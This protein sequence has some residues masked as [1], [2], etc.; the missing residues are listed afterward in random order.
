MHDVIIVG[1][2]VAGLVCGRQLLR[3]G[4]DVLLVEKSAGLGGRM[5]TRRIAYKSGD[6]PIAVDHGAQYITADTD[7]FHRLI[8][9][10]VVADVLVEWTRSIHHL[11]PTG[12]HPG[13]VD[14][15]HPRYSSPLGM[16]AFAKYLAGSLKIEINTQV[17]HI[18]T[19]NHYWQVIAKDGKQFQARSLV[20][21]IPAPQVLGVMGEILKQSPLLGLLKSALYYPCLTVIAG[22]DPRISLPA[23][24][25]IT[26]KQDPILAWVGLDSS[27]RPSPQIPVIVFQATASFSEKITSGETADL[28]KA[29]LEVLKHASQ[30]LDRWMENPQWMQV[31]RWRYAL[32]METV[33]LASLAT[34]MP[35]RAPLV[36]AGDW[37][38]G[39]KVEGAWSSGLDAA[40]Q[41][42][43]L[44]GISTLPSRVVH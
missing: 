6:P 5:S 31:H 7:A 34:R 23:W 4:L 25:G 21:A 44:L 28:Q 32:P 10:L 17:T 40:E 2:G 30:R 38:A 26:C 36:C 16:T 39:G 29:G 19:E 1:A 15:Q 18:K 27:K 37:C 8:R 42:L 22:F 41:L 20:M 12:L 9:E 24:K 11:D 33:G 14:H 35:N 3:A 43:S 13:S